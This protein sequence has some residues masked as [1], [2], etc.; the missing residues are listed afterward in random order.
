ME[1]TS[2]QT[3]LIEGALGEEVT[4]EVTVHSID[5]E[6]YFATAEIGG[7]SFSL[8]YAVHTPFSD[9]EFTILNEDSGEGLHARVTSGDYEVTVIDADGY[10]TFGAEDDFG[11]ADIAGHPDLYLALLLLQVADPLRHEMGGSHQEV[12]DEVAYGVT[13][14]GCPVEIVAVGIVA[15]G[16]IIV[17]CT[18]SEQTCQGPTRVWVTCSECADGGYWK[19]DRCGCGESVC[20]RCWPFNTCQ[21]EC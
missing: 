3:L 20:N 14:L 18:G 11:E 7:E 12:G 5:A 17:A 9:E 6:W 15:G 8:Q 4:V 21:D 19:Y 16:I 13:I 2:T 10:E 1:V